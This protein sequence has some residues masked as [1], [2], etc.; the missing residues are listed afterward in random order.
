MD[1]A[2]VNVF[3]INNS[4]LTSKGKPEVILIRR[5]WLD[6]AGPVTRNLWEP[7][8]LEEQQLSLILQSTHYLNAAF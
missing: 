7:D 8:T 5:K 4:I 1:P 6:S 2:S 3:A